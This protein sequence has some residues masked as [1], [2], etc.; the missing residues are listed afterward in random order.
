MFDPM[1]T[2]PAP[3]LVTVWCPDWSIAAAR[4]S[5]VVG[6]DEP[7]AV[8]R[9]GRVVARSEAAARAGV[10]AGQR[11]RQAQRCCPE[12]VL[13]DHDPGRDAR[14]FEPVVRAVAE[15]V[16]RLDLVEPGWLMFAARGPSRYFGG[17]T[18]LAE[19]LVRLVHDLVG[20]PVGIGVA[21]GRVTSAIA[22]RR[23]A[24]GRGGPAGSEAGGVDVVAPGGSA[25]YLAPLSVAWLR[26]LGD[27]SPELIDVLMRLGLRTMGALAELPAAEVLARFGRD[28]E[29]ARHLARGD[30]ARPPVVVDPAPDRRVEHT[31]DEPVV[32]VSP[33]V[34]IAKQLADHLIA[35]LAAEGRMCARLLVTAETDHGERTERIWYRDAGFSAP[36]IVERVRW[37]LDAW[38]G[39][40]GGISA[41][42][43]MVRLEPVELRAADGVQSGLWG[44]RS[45]ADEDAVRAVARLS[46]LCGTE[47]VQVPVWRGGRLPAER[48]GWVPAA[49]ADL[50]DPSSR[51][52]EAGAPWA[53]AITDPAPT[54]VPV[55]PVEVELFDHHGHRVSVGGRGELGAEPAVLAVGGARHAVT[56][57]AGPWPVEQAWWDPRRARRIARLEVLT[58]DGVARLVGA[59]HRRWW[60]LGEHR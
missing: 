3:R 20:A 10:V 53:G 59:E 46:A 28:G 4:M 21:E 47:A 24:A 41:G 9:A 7:A 22:A 13:V 5:G 49:T 6:H 11:R 16:P 42:I 33:V 25:G 44:G 1:E 43:V 60:V 8:M 39:Q 23:A 51:L 27:A 14:S 18:A 15:M 56:A 19:R 17:D 30:D 52:A 36:A 31:F 2:S 55:E 58:D 45:Q 32:S 29:L 12:L 40:P 54:V 38:V 57:W 26:E 50:D 37:Q 34:F 35:E 48:F